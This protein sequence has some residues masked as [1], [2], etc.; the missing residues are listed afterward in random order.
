VSTEPDWKATPP[1]SEMLTERTAS[2]VPRLRQ[3]A[4]TGEQLRRL[5][6]D[7]V[8]A[9]EEAGLFRML[10]P[11]RRGGYGTDVAT[12]AKV[13]TLIAGGCA[14]TAWVMM[15][16]NSVSELAELLSDDALSEIYADRHP[17]I[18]GV[19]GRAGAVIQRIEGGF[20]VRS[21]GRWPFN[22]GCHHATWDLLRLTVE[23]AD[24]S[25]WPAFAAVPM[26]ELTICDDWDVMGALGTGSSSVT[27]GELIIPE[28]RVARV[29][30]DLQAVIRSDVS[31]AQNCALPLG[32]ARY[33]LEAFLDLARKQGINH[34]GYAQMGD[35]PVVQTAVAR[36]AIDIKLIETYQQ[37]A[38]STFANGSDVNPQAAALQPIGPVRCF[39]LARGVIE[40]LLALCP[41]TEIHRTK[42]IQRL[43]RDIH[44]FEHQ[45][46][47]TPFINYALYGR[48][49]FAS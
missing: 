6:D 26:A 37:W 27:C 43:L 47:L 13:L 12:I 19:F 4:T 10:Q 14:S 34:L 28:H 36:A 31:A 48:R 25:T 1:S 32:M 23:E 2:L 7:T 5:P 46:A 35:A 17:R 38:L 16:Y 8:R 24:G 42:P 29:P 49:L 9:L 30:K 44:V 18:A 21:G 41:S 45:H 15:I 20:R 11:I 22:S 3:N 40:R 33:A 39:E